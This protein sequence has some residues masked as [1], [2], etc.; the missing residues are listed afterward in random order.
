MGG[1]SAPLWV[2]IMLGVLAVVGT[3]GGAWGGQIIAARRDDRRWER[4]QQREDLRWKRDRER[5]HERLD[6]ER[7]R[8]EVRRTHDSRIEWRLQRFEVCSAFV[9]ALDRCEPTYYDR[10]AFQDDPLE[11][12][13][14][15]EL[16]QES[17]EHL[18]ELAPALVQVEFLATKHVAEEARRLQ[19][20]ATTLS[21][22]MYPRRPYPS[23][24]DP[25][26]VKGSFLKALAE[27]ENARKDFM[28]TV[29][30]ELGLE[31]TRDGDHQTPSP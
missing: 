23:N 31:V 1:A 13:R 26:T 16:R 11:I 30:V 24:T 3:V 25:A 29:K 28:S 10:V 7:D 22:V 15:D 14:R 4:E 27:L 5:E 2:T 12:S 6:V 8:D 21:R 9:T 18:N 19:R 20:L 17:W